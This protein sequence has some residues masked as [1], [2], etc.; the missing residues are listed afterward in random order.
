MNF[1]PAS[2]HSIC[3]QQA[4]L[5]TYLPDL[6]CVKR[7]IFQGALE[8]GA[9]FALN[10]TNTE[11]GVTLTISASGFSGTLISLERAELAVEFYVTSHR[12]ARSPLWAIASGN[13]QGHAE[14]ALWNGF[15]EIEVPD[16]LARGSDSPDIE[17]VPGRYKLTAATY[18]IATLFIGL[19]EVRHRM[20][21]P[22]L[23]IRSAAG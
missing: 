7:E 8:P 20:Q 21:A 6:I 11:Y 15:G 19:D 1:L 18:G 2:N 3:V 17:L 14:V 12:R 13:S 22:K 5:S 4:L 10:P 16:V 23:R 9:R